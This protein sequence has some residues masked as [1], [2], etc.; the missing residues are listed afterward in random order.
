MVMFWSYDLNQQG[1]SPYVS[2]KYINTPSEKNSGVCIYSAIK[3]FGVENKIVYDYQSAISELLDKNGKGECKYYAVWVFCGPPLPIFPPKDG[4]INTT[5]PHLVGEF[6]NILIEFWKN[7]GALI[8]FADGEPLNFQ[9]NLFLDK[10]D[11][12]KN[13]SLFNCIFCY[14][15]K[16]LYLCA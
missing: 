3:H 11:F 14:S 7:G 9:V 4:I 8:F 1:E 15:K 16:V 10:I 13:E 5:N 12:S 2:P 6:I